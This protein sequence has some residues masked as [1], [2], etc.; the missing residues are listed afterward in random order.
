MGEGRLW[1]FNKRRSN[2]I[3]SDKAISCATVNV[4]MAIHTCHNIIMAINSHD[5]VKIE[6]CPHHGATV[7]ACPCYNVN[8]T[9][10]NHAIGSIMFRSASDLKCKY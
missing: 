4:F 5:N 10:C 8:I 7:E 2:D 1:S 9:G 3:T 6:I